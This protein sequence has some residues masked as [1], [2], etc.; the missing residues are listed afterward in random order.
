MDLLIYRGCLGEVWVSF[1]GHV[2]EI[3]WKVCGTCF[4]TFSGGE[5]GGFFGRVCEGKASQTQTENNINLFSYLAT[6]V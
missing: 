6:A 1:G 4:V 2:G 3:V 5:L